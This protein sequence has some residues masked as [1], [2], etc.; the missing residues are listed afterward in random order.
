MEKRWTPGPWVIERYKEPYTSV[1]DDIS[2]VA[3]GL[4]LAKLGKEL[5]TEHTANANLIGA[6][7][8]LYNALEQLRLAVIYTDSIASIYIEDAEEAL[9]KARGEIGERGE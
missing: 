1:I 9:A 5:S 3:D 7:P 6:A 2:I 8:D 4:I